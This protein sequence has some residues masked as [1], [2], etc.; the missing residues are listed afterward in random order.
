MN[1]YKCFLMTVAIISFSLF[2]SVIDLKAGTAGILVDCVETANPHGKKT[3]PAGRT[4]LPGPM[5][6][7]NEDGFYELIVREGDDVEL[8]VEDQGSGAVFGPFLDR[9]KIKYTEAPGATPSSKTI[10]STTGQAGA[11]TVHITG[12]GDM[13]VFGEDASGNESDLV[14]CL[15]PP[16][17]K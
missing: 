16:P 2:F 11:I 12:T 14:F 4:T 13:G 17:P 3:P 5:G 6:G 1:R 10:G 7:Q 15:V 8:F 9:D